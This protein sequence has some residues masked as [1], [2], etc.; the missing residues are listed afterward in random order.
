MA[1]TVVLSTRSN[2]HTQRTL[3]NNITKTNLNQKSVQL[4]EYYV[5]TITPSQMISQRL[6]TQ[7]YHPTRREKHYYKTTGSFYD[8]NYYYNND[9]ETQWF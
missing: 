4:F 9:Y 2:I 5:P 8:H 1:T 3:V 6:I 7:H